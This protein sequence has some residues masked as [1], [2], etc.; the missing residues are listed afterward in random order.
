MNCK[1]LDNGV[2]IEYLQQI[3]KIKYHTVLTTA[4]IKCKYSLCKDNF[5]KII[6][7]CIEHESFKIKYIARNG[8][9]HY[10]N[11][12]FNF[13]NVINMEIVINLAGKSNDKDEIITELN[14]QIVTLNDRIVTLNNTVATLE[15][16]I[17]KIE[18]PKMLRIGTC[19]KK[20]IMYNQECGQNSLLVC[21]TGDTK[22]IISNKIN[23]RD[24]KI[25]PSFQNINCTSMI[26]ENIDSATVYTYLPLTVNTLD[27][28]DKQ[29]YDAFIKFHNRKNI[30]NIKSLEIY[31]DEIID[32]LKLNTLQTDNLKVY[33]NTEIYMDISKVKKSIEISYC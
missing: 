5:I 8:C 24:I 18:N 17:F 1:I 26:F 6:H 29:S 32:L 9:T 15:Q 16:K 28:Y 13:D 4:N 33:L 20:E 2:E 3:D 31:V 30:K 27:F 23:V 10:V 14:D 7:W 12:I 19:G 22:K 11:A 21:M 25:L